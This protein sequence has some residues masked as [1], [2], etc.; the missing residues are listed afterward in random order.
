[1]ASIALKVDVPFEQLA[2]ANSITDPNRV[3]AGRRLT[4][5]T[6]PSGVE[7][8]RR[9]ATLSAAAKRLRVRKQR[10]TALNPQITF[11]PGPLAGGLLRVGDHRG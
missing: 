10:L 7:V 11:P 1:M 9:G 6:R 3:V 8:I 4:I 2:A 5:T